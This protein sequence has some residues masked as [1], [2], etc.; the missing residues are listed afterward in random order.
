MSNRGTM[1]WRRSDAK[2]Q[3][4]EIKWKQILNLTELLQLLI[5]TNTLVNVVF[6]L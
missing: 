2:L 4:S 5:Y 1:I 6:E 3:K